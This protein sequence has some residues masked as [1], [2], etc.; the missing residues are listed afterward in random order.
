VRSIDS[1]DV[2]GQSTPLSESCHRS[3]WPLQ[4]TIT[5]TEGALLIF[6]H[7]RVEKLLAWVAGD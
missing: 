7:S 4:I 2:D 1:G 3:L 5:L 6:L